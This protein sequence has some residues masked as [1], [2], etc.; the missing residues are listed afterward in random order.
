MFL[1][2][3]NIKTYSCCEFFRA[4]Q[5]HITYNIF[6][7]KDS[8]VYG[9]NTKVKYVYD[10][11]MQRLEIQKLYDNAGNIILQKK[12]EYDDIG[13]IESQENS[14]NFAGNNYNFSNSY[15]YDEDNRLVLAQSN[16]NT[17]AFYGLEMRYSEAGRIVSKDFG[18]EYLT[19][20][21]SVNNSYS[22]TYRYTNTDNPYAV[23]SIGL[24]SFCW[25]ELGNLAASNMRKEQQP[26]L[27][28]WTED[29]RMQ[30]YNDIA[31]S[32]SAF[33]RYDASGQR[34]LKLTGELVDIDVMNNKH[35]T[36]NYNN[37]VLYAGNLM[38]IDKSGYK[39]HYFIENER[40]L[41]VLGGGKKDTVFV[42]DVSTELVGIALPNTNNSHKPTLPINPIPATDL[43]HLFTG[44]ITSYYTTHSNFCFNV[45]DWYSDFARNFPS[46]PQALNKNFIAGGTDVP[47]YWH[48]DY[49][50]SGSA[51]TNSAGNAVQ[52][53]DYAPFGEDLL[54]LNNGFET[55][56]K[57]AGYIKDA[58]SGM[59]YMG[60]RYNNSKIS[61]N[62]ST[63]PMWR[64]F[65]FISPYAVNLNNP[66]MLVDPDGNSPW[67]THGVRIFTFSAE[68]GV[69]VM[70]AV[71]AGYHAGMA[72]DKHGTTHFS[73]YSTQYVTNQNLHEGSRHPSFI[74]GGGVGVSE[75]FE[76]NTRYD[77]YIESLWSS[78]LSI[79]AKYFSIG[80]GDDSYSL[81]LGLTKEIG[82]KGAQQ[83]IIESISLSRNESK[84]AGAL[85]S[86]TVTGATLKEDENGNSYY[87]GKVE[88]KGIFSK[89]QT[90]ITVS[91]AAVLDKNGKYKSNGIW[92][93][94]E[95][96]KSMEQY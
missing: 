16:S 15:G 93:S 79:N 22:N 33:Y 36:A 35:K 83:N 80:G 90:D 19:N 69:G 5:C 78:S 12:Y 63:E 54:D 26:K 59:Y 28:Y 84:K 14:Y 17:A 95:Y 38:T 11:V 68:V 8:I 2:A 96:Q 73:S 70:Y 32:V 25:D 34:E 76:Y 30:A 94:K 43:S 74:V 91:S 44:F 23:S 47:Y 55:D 67:P 65:P 53:L 66:I 72:F 57:F 13:N 87:E 27:M 45:L 86:W 52:I 85:N 40:F 64:D 51:I 56:Y 49:L 71:G 88:S 75:G 41:T 81:S 21:I 46:L 7:Q 3:K 20:S 4:K 6:E 18:S 9:N 61:I 31:S 42:I 89:R 77:S 82:A 60:A 37:A 39:K 48:S 58:E 29:N 1:I 92:M 50:G 62:I 10:N 24:E